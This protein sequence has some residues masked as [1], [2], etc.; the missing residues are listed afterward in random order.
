MAAVILIDG[1]VVLSSASRALETAPGPS[2]GFLAIPGS[3]HMGAGSPGVL[4][5]LD[6][7]GAASSRS[8]RFSFFC[9]CLEATIYAGHSSH[10]YHC[11]LEFPVSIAMKH[12]FK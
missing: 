10:V 9:R 4:L 8:P 3:G 12:V 1:Y 7:D 11:F 6:L 5:A 2:G